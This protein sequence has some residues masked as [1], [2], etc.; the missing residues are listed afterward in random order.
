MRLIEYEYQSFR[1][2]EPT[3][4][5]ELTKY[6]YNSDD[7]HTSEYGV[8]FLFAELIK[9]YGVNI[10]CSLMK[11]FRFF[12]SESGRFTENLRKQLA[13]VYYALDK[14]LTGKRILDLGCG[15]TGD[16]LESTRSKREVQTYGPWLCRLLHKLGVEVTGVDAGSLEGEKFSAFGGVDLLMPESLGFL[17]SGYFDLVHSSLLYSSPELNKRVT[18]RTSGHGSLIVG[19]TLA[20]TLMPQ[21]ERVL[22]SDGIYIFYDEDFYSLARNDRIKPPTLADY[23]G[24][25]HIV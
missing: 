9:E 19:E 20:T 1:H 10:D 3:G 21:I 4:V 15:S 7:P 24:K 6:S 12:D 8:P 5:L 2:R 18:G 22:K 17:P 14:D 16:T 13:A 25:T 23:P 11:C